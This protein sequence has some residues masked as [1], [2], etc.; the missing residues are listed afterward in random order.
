[1]FLK[2]CI[3][4]NKSKTILNCLEQR[5]KVKKPRSTAINVT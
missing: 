2:K 3:W 5:I 1:M 4:I